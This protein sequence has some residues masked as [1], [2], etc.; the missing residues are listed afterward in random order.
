MG[1][2]KMQMIKQINEHKNKITA[3]SGIL[4]VL[5]FLLPFAGYERYKDLALITATLIAI[6]PI[7]I[8]AF[9]ALRMKAFSIELLVTIA[10]AGALYI[11]EYTES[12]VVTFLFLFGAYLEAR[13]LEKTR[14]SLKALVDMAPQE[15]DVIRD[16]E[17]LTIPVEEVVIGDR[18]L[19]ARRQGSVDGSIVSGK[20]TLNEAAITGESVP[21]SKRLMIRFLAARSLIMVI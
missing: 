11:H 17:N 19:S 20:A 18:L 4:I 10:V 5:G 14:S 12:S 2:M 1:G 13:T 7:A 6:V 9:Q 21:A 16:G 15:A 8:R 3:I